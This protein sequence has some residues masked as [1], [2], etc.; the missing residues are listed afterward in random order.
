MPKAEI[1]A[2]KPEATNGSGDA[3]RTKAPA[4]RRQ[5]K[6]KAAH[7]NNKEKTAAGP[8]HSRADKRRRRE[9]PS[10]RCNFNAGSVDIFQGR[11]MG[12]M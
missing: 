9:N 2:N 8:S 1:T 12:G 10:A 7:T 11:I 4:I 5:A 6:N 3:G